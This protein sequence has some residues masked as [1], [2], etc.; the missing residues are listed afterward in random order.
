MQKEIEQR[1]SNIEKA[2]GAQTSQS[3]GSESRHYDEDEID[4]LALWN[5]VWQGKWII[6]GITF[7]FAL[8]SVFYALSLPNIYRAQALLAPSE[9]SQGGGLSALAGQFGGLASLAGVDLGGG[10]TDKSVIAIELM[11]SRR[12][13]NGFIH[14]HGLLVPLVAAKGWDRNADRLILDSEIFEEGSGKWVRDVSPPKTA[15]PSDWEAYKY[16]REIFVVSQDKKTGLVTVSVEHFSPVTAQQWVSLLVSEINMFMRSREITEAEKSIE[17]LT[18]ELKSTS[19]ADMRTVFSQLIE[20]QTKK[21]MLASVR[22]EYTF[23]TIDPA[24]KP[25]EKDSPKRSLIVLLA[26]ILGGI[27]GLIT[28]FVR[29]M[30]FVNGSQNESAE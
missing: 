11:K 28:V 18:Q 3:L 29:H 14:K 13:V 8:A 27:V 12:F 7:V 9:E 24:V 23:T 22:Q 26:L 2:L 10:S 16:F 20:E 15:K 19:V 30:F 5:V 25:E 6:I 21:V 1:L 17:F 4:L